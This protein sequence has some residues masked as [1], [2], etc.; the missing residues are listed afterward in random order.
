[1]SCRM[2]YIKVKTILS[3]VNYGNDWYCIDFNINLY[4]GCTHGCIYC[5]SRSSAIRG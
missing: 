2:K 4:R 1:M 3:K 5:Y